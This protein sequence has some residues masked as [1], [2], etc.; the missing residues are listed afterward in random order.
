MLIVQPSESNDEAGVC[1]S[2]HE[3]ENPLREETSTGPPRIAQ[4]DAEIAGFLLANERSPIVD[5]PVFQPEFPSSAMFPS[6]IP[7]VRL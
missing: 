3:G 6:A 1:Y 5:G 4:R 2:L 7:A